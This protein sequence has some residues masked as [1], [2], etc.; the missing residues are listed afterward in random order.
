[1]YGII[2]SQD[3]KE[4]EK[5]YG[6]PAFHHRDGEL[7]QV[8][9]EAARVQ[10]DF[11]I[12]DV[13]FSH[14]IEEELHQ[15]RVQR[16]FTR[17]I[18]I[19]SGREP[20]DPLIAK[21]V[22]MGIY[23]IVNEEGENIKTELLNR[24]KSP[25]T[26]TQGARWIQIGHLSS[27]Q[28]K[29]SSSEAISETVIQ[30]RPLGLTTIAIAG[31][32]SGT[33]VSHLSLAIAT[34]LARYNNRVVLAEWSVSNKREVCS[35]YKYLASLGAST[36]KKKINGVKIEL[37]KFNNIDIFLDARSY[38][39]IDYVFPFIKE[40]N[41]L[42]LDLGEITPEKITEMDRAA[43]S[44][45]VVSGSPYRIEKFLPLIDDN[46]IGIYTSNL[47]RWKIAVNLTKEKEMKW[48]VNTFKKALGEI[49]Y[50]PYFSSFKEETEVIKNIL[51][52]FLPLSSPRKKEP[53]WKFI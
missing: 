14:Y 39:S 51:E 21:L 52:P 31:A 46:E 38:R 11:L 49:Y 53:F 29:K 4:L 35:Q 12:V 45:L 17:I 42:V 5:L 10:L 1:M 40:Y 16:P 28:S 25:A 22:N 19:A 20:G 41:Y 36:E 47:A 3:F 32:G 48:F 34:H 13:N 43:L 18:L 37:A 24:I 26:Y 8:L 50:I 27:S 2:S 23:D 9:L 6:V 7:R 30:Q 44:I 15:Y 33:G